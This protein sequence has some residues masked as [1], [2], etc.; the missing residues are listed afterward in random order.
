MGRKTE[1]SIDDRKFG[2]RGLGFGAQTEKKSLKPVFF[3]LLL[4][5]LDRKRQTR[6]AFMCVHKHARNRKRE[7]KIGVFVPNGSWSWELVCCW[8]LGDFFSVMNFVVDFGMVV[9]F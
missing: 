1:K 3:C 9:D 2:K 5:L 4:L 6:V 7:R 8:L